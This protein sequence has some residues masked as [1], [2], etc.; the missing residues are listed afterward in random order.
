MTTQGHDYESVVDCVLFL[1]QNKVILPPLSLPQ[2]W[3]GG[4]IPPQHPESCKENLLRN[5]QKPLQFQT[6]PIQVSEIFKNTAPSIRKNI[7]KIG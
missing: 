1:H 2:R 4:T 6:T 5:K 3:G 7:R